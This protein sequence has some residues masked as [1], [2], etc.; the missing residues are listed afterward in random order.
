LSSFLLT[1]PSSVLMLGLGAEL[2]D[3]TF[4][5]RLGVLELASLGSILR[6]QPPRFR[7]RLDGSVRHALGLVVDAVAAVRAVCPSPL[8]PTAATTP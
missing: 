2:A 5:R 7:L 1:A 8:W 4:R 3:V 6:S